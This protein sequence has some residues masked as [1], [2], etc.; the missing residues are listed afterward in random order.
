MDW[1]FID[2]MVVSSLQVPTTF[3]TVYSLNLVLI[4]IFLYGIITKI[5]VLIRLTYL[6]LFLR[7]FIE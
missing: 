5:S 1:S 6:Y 4:D 2:F 3:L 7:F